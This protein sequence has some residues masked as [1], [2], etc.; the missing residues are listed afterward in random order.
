ML[1]SFLQLAKAD[2]VPL[3]TATLSYI[4]DQR[5]KRAMVEL[6]VSSGS[7]E[8]LERALT[9]ART[10]SE[11]PFGLNLWQAQNIWYD[12]FR[13]SNY[14]LTALAD[15]QRPRWDK[16]FAELGSCLAIDTVAIT[17]QDQLAETIG[18]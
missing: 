5:M 9:L 4:A 6:Q 18:D 13:S 14:A 8:M 3:E 1:R 10:L 17:A 2:Q 7:L 11:M 15:E 12:T 16:D